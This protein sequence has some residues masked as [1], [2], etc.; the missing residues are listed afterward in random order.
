MLCA[1]QIFIPGP[2]PVMTSADTTTSDIRG[3][4]VPRCVVCSSR[5]AI[6]TCPRCTIQTC[7]LHCS[8]AH[9]TRTGCSGVRD[10]TKFVPMNRY[11]HGTMMDD[12]VFLE[13]MSR[14]V[15][16]C[17]QDIVR[18][19]YRMLRGGGRGRGAAGRGGPGRGAPEKKRDTLKLQLE[20][21]D[22]EMD[23]LPPG[24]ERRRLNH[25]TWDPKCVSGLDTVPMA[26][27][28]LTPQQAKGS[29]FDG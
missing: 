27:P 18:N 15:G 29:F 2:H 6:Y 23:L 1:V 20:L 16:G 14:R 26:E 28:N 8:T 24:M 3:S 7:S 4:T 5:A 12:Y 13:E 21:R 25:S 11:T 9:K 10:K 22:I 19:G 17:G